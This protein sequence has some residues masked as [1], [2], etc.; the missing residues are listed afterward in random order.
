MIESSQARWEDRYKAA[1]E[2]LFGEAPSE[3]LRQVAARSDFDAQSALFLADGDGR[4]SRW[5]ASRGCRVTSVDFSEVATAKARRADQEQ[6]I[7]VDRVVADLTAWRGAERRFDA[8]FVIAFH[9]E[10]AARRLAVASALDHVTEKGWFMLEG[11]TRSQAVR[12]TMGPSDASR[13]YDR[14][15]LLSW[16]PDSFDCLEILEGTVLLSEGPGHQGPA[17]MVRLLARRR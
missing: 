3:Y 2:P 10:E 15:T 11:F 8:V 6:G 17:D 13:L 1:T 5:L 7:T 14:E 16:M 4:N 12:G 9:A